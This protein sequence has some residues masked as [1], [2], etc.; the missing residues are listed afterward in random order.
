[1]SYNGANLSQ[2]ENLI[3]GQQKEW[4]YLTTDALTSV[5]A[6]GYFSDGVK[7]GMKLGDL[8][9]VFKTDTPALY[10]QKVSAVD[11]GFSSGLY[12]ATVAAV[13][14]DAS[15]NG[16]FANLTA[17]GNI[18]LASAASKTVG[19]FGASSTSQRAGAAQAT[20]NLTTASSTAIDTQTKAALIEVINTLNALGLMKGS[21]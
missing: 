13:D 18:Q 10:I 16:S 12:T 15:Q 6:A 4:W 2:V 8:V 9:F 17:T 19:F 11:A 1:M 21:A 20:S 3:G 7:R 14:A 5:Q